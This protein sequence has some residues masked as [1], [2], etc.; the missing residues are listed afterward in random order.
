M[1]SIGQP[2]GSGAAHGLCVIP[3]RWHIGRAQRA[4]RRSFA[5]V[6]TEL[7]PAAGM[8]ELDHNFSD[9][10]SAGL[11]SASAFLNCSCRL[12]AADVPLA[13]VL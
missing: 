1:L 2:E 10:D 4:N 7:T 11:P 12:C 8:R 3:R 6:G 13:E 5:M 9:R